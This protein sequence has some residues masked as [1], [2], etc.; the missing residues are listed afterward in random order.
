MSE[1]NKKQNP[2]YSIKLLDPTVDKKKGDTIHIFKNSI[3]LGR[4]DACTVQYIDN[5]ISVSRLHAEIFIN[6]EGVFVKNGPESKNQIFI[7]KKVVQGDGI[8][9]K[10]KDKVQLS[11]NGPQFI[12]LNK[13]DKNSASS[14]DLLV[15]ASFIILLISV[16]SL[17]LS[18]FFKN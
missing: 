6:E 11:Y 18:L 2:L 15:W 4:S 10:H 3:F 7:N 1:N 16:L 14:I 17:V 8:R 13:G 9:L 5:W 12:I